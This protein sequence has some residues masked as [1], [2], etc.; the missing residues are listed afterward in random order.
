MGQGRNNVKEF[1][2]AHPDISNAVSAKLRQALG[3]SERG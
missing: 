2:K 3:F 1:F